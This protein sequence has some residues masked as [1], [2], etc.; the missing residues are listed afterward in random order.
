M[1]AKILLFRQSTNINCKKNKISILTQAGEEV[2][3]L[4]GA[5]GGVV[6]LLEAGQLAQLQ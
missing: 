1:H 2:M 4:E 6:A 3:Q 5:V